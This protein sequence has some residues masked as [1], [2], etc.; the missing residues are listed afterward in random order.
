MNMEN[1]YSVLNTF[2]MR[3]PLLPI[4]EYMNIFN[5]K[6]CKEESISKILEISKNPLLREV[7]A[8]SSPILLKSLDDYEK[9]SLKKQRLIL[10][11]LIRY[12]IRMT[13]RTTPFGLCAAV[14]T[15]EFKDESNFDISAPISHR[16]YARPDMEWIFKVV[17]LV[18]S[19]I[20]SLE[21]LKLRTNEAILEKGSRVKLNFKSNYGLKE[22]MTTEVSS[23]RLT[24]AVRVLLDYTNEFQPCEAILEK[25]S[26][27]F[28]S[29]SRDTL[30]KFIFELLQQE[31]LVSDLRPP[32]RDFDPFTYLINKLSN[33]EGFKVLHARLVLIR[34]EI[35]KYNSLKIGEGESQYFYIVRLMKEIA[36]SKNTLQ[37][38][39]E[40][41][42]KNISLQES[43]KDDVKTAANVI[44][45]LSPTIRSPLEDYKH[46]FIERYG[47]NQD[48]PI[49]RLVD[50]DQGL[51]FPNYKN[52]H[53][54]PNPQL[55]MLLHQW[56][57]ECINNN[58]QEIVLT[59]EML[60]KVTKD[61]NKTRK[62]STLDLYLN[63]H[64]KSTESIS[65]GNYELIVGASAGTNGAGKTFGRFHHM[66]N[67]DFE[68]NNKDIKQYEQN[69]YPNSILADLSYLPLRSR[70]SN[71]TISNSN[72]NFE[73]P[74]GT[75]SSKDENHT[76]H[77]EDLLIGCT[78]EGFYIKSRRLKKE[79]IVVSDHL[80]N[81][82][83][84]PN[85]GRL[86]IEIS[87]ERLGVWTY[88]QW[89]NLNFS[90]FLPRLRYK[91]IILCR[92]QWNI[93]KDNPELSRDLTNE[94][95]KTKFQCWRDKY[96]VPQ[97]V[98]LNSGDNRLLF[99]L[100]EPLHL[101]QLR[102]DYE[103]LDDRGVIGLTE[104][105][106]YN[107]L[108]TPGPV[109]N[110]KSQ[111][112][113][114]ELVFSL[115]DNAAK[116]DYG[117]VNKHFL[118]S[119]N[120]LSNLENRL[121]LPGSEWLYLKIY[122]V[123]DRQ[124]EFISTHLNSVVSKAL[125][126][127]WATRYFF[128]RYKDPN[129][130]IRLRFN[131]LSSKLMTEGMSCIYEWAR[132]LQREGA[133][134][135]FQI[136]TY[137]PEIERYGGVHLLNKA[138]DIFWRDSELVQYWLSQNKEKPFHLSNET[139]S[140]ISIIDYLEQFKLSKT[141][142][143]NWFEERFNYKEFSKEFRQ[144]KNELIKYFNIYSKEKAR[145]GTDFFSNLFSVRK[146]SIGNF[147]IKMSEVKEYDLTNTP[148]EIISSFIHL[149][150]NRLIGINRNKEKELMSL[151][152]NTLRDM[153]NSEK[154]RGILI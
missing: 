82:K 81:H 114:A 16:K 12:F 91:N 39:L 98:F 53:V 2:M 101:E 60:N 14:T 33:D 140:V 133:I 79:V 55:D 111:S 110:S 67:G 147:L 80:L 83:F 51:G 76:I 49:L 85:I 102:R 132:N 138:E 146:Q 115:I 93:T 45:K 92:A 153:I 142:Q 52:D 65:K 94:E 145:A 137:D 100:S 151:A 112:Y 66:G 10:K 29:T 128:M 30:K 149:H 64:S 24:Q 34:D 41:N 75:N 118:N 136:D 54:E 35:K 119:Y 28:P 6:L 5:N 8:V 48:I 23:I 46:A 63:L 106:E 56:F 129:P 121:Y 123:S 42:D 126:S 3:I 7:L 37:V 71:I 11:S 38:D 43:L 15:S 90:P 21:V 13:T 96:N 50:P 26:K 141:E 86:L 69:I 120:S 47:L 95:W 20:Y 113:T 17:K 122:G 109:V 144:Q 124:D 18:E 99:N 44:S 105:K 74:L 36:D 150:L 87:N 107:D 154:Y 61:D 31:Y 78:F 57:F 116:P 58:E 59:D 135:H 19:N 139:F 40:L 131:G 148:D 70:Y 152:Y 117:N 4:N 97:Y 130:H 25:L 134:H 88:F 68:K 143:L 62:S 89:H 22:D 27:E 9:K 77:L 127:G 1:D 125:E 32:L 84:A 73:I 72:R 103:K 108:I 104:A